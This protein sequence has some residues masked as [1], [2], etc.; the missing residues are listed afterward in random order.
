[1]PAL[2]SSDI[3][4]VLKELYPTGV[5]LEQV[6][7]DCPTLA[8]M[9]QSTK[10]GGKDVLFPILWGNP[11]GRSAN[12]TTAQTN[13]TGSKFAGFAVTTVDDYA[14]WGISGK[15]IAQ[16]RDD[17]MA[18]VRHLKTEMDG[19]ITQL[20]RSMHHSLFRNGGGALG[21]ISAGSTIGSTTITLTNKWDVCFFEVG[22]VL[23]SSATDGTSG[24]VR[25]G[26]VTITKLDRTAGTLTAS[27][28]WNA[29]ITAVA[30]NDF[31]FVDGDFGL[32]M[33]G[34]DAWIPA[35]APGATLFYGV[36]RS[37]DVVRLGGSRLDAA[38]TANK[39]IDE[40]IMD[41]LDEQCTQGGSPDVVIMHTRQF[42][43][44]EK[45]LQSRVQF[46]TREMEVGK[47]KFGVRTIV[48]NGPKGPVDVI[49]DMNAR[50]DTVLGLDLST[51]ELG[52]LGP[53]FG[54]LDDDDLPFLR[55]ATADEIEG[56][57]VSR[58]GLAC[59]APGFNCRATVS[60]SGL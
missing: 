50:I 30:V 32:K 7:K 9:P 42:T 54:M 47:V 15:A 19:A 53:L 55:V 24:A 33:P 8:L 49:A 39:P 29:G 5:P 36:D 2:L 17:N 11:Q 43:N 12:I 14:V 58:P 13:K 25:T 1:M 48:V 27:G 26:T 45:R 23:K 51:W 18:F 10:W 44:L 35:A 56:R 46:G 4:S 41:L 3:A 60:V 20:K 37:S 22:Q 34:F 40:V 59:K 6:Y 28:N 38:S 57:L 16:S 52:S 31:L 21:Q